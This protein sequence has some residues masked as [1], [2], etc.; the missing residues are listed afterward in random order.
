MLATRPR[1]ALATAPLAAKAHYSAPV[2]FAPRAH[3]VAAQKARA[4]VLAAADVGTGK[5][6]VQGRNVEATPAIKSYCEEKVG[7]AIRNFDGIKEVGSS[8]L[9]VGACASNQADAAITGFGAQTVTLPSEPAC[10]TGSWAGVPAFGG[11]RRQQRPSCCP[12]LCRGPCFLPCQDGF[13]ASWCAP[14]VCMHL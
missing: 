3:R 4:L 1:P 5:I 2:A 9:S 12:P 7:K 8:C 13:R 10:E 14:P 11:G 6:V